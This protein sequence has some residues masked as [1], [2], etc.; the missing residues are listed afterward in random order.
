MYVH[1]GG[2]ENK[3][4][5]SYIKMKYVGAEILK[6]AFQDLSISHQQGIVKAF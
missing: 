3:L 2:K 6:E 4:I 5:S 1:I